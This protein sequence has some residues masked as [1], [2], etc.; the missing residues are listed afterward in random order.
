MSPAR[1]Y[2]SFEVGTILTA[3]EVAFF[4]ALFVN[5]ITLFDFHTGIDDRNE[6]DLFFFHILYKALEIR[7]TFFIY[8]EVLVILHVVNIHVNHIERHMVFA[9]FFHY[10]AEIILCFVAPAALTVTESKL[11]SNVA[12]SDNATELLYD[13]KIGIT[14]DHVNVEICVFAGNGHRIGS[15]VADI[16]TQGARIIE[17]ESYVCLAGDDDEVVCC[18]QRGFALYVI[19]IIGAV[20]DV[21]KAAFVDTA[22]GF[23]K[24]EYHVIVSKFGGEGEAVLGG[25]GT[26]IRVS[27]GSRD[28]FYNS[29]GLKW[30]SV[31]KFFYHVILLIK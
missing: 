28:L 26:I 29:F 27:F 10:R 1:P 11:R 22:V 31:D 16:E 15:C 17:E 4:T 30:G 8:G 18:I 25:E 24:S 21:K 14:G 12:A 6:M 19:R 7:E 9:V 20:T 5:V 23:T 2:S 3:A 13:I